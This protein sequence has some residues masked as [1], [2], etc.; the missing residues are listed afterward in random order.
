[1]SR[2]T[3]KM[4]V[5]ILFINLVSI[6]F[7]KAQENLEVL[8]DRV[9]EAVGYDELKNWKDGFRFEA[10]GKAGGYKCQFDFQFLADGRFQMTF[11]SQLKEVYCF[12]GN[13]GWYTDYTGLTYPM[14]YYKLEVKKLIAWFISSHW[15]DPECH[16]DMTLN[17]INQKRST[18][19]ISLKVSNGVVGAMIHIN[20]DDYFPEKFIPM[21]ILLS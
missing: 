5:I 13:Q 10:M 17:S 4:L 15:L 12:D 14:E 8:L 2:F 19:Q 11:D 6:H 7:C 20:T 3:L 1:M 21:R 18:A 16:L 9:R